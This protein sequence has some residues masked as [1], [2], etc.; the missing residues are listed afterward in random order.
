MSALGH[1]E[2][3]AVEL[4]MS[5]RLAGADVLIYHLTRYDPCFLRKILWPNPRRGVANV[6]ALVR[7]ASYDSIAPE[8]PGRRHSEEIRL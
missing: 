5:A 8:W 6:T 1:S 3:S 4:G 7:A 2:Q